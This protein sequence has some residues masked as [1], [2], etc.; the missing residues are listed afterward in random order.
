[1]V[2]FVFCLICFMNNGTTDPLLPKTFPYLTIENFVF[3]FPLM[4]FADDTNLSEHNFVAPYKFIGET[5]LSVDSATNFSI[6][7]SKATSIKFCVP[8]ILFFKN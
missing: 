5:A 4:L 2:N 7:F 6:L 3:L 1:M 8:I